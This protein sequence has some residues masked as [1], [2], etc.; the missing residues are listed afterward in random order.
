MNHLIKSVLCAATLATMNLAGAADLTINIDDVKSEAGSI[1]VA[2][3]NTSD[4]FLKTPVKQG[5]A[6]A[7]LAG[8]KI[9]ITDLPPGDY[10]FSLYQDLNDNGKIDTNLMG[11]P[12]EPYAFSNNAMGSMGPPSFDN[13]KF[14]V[15]S[16]AVAATVTL[17]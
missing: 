5:A 1:L 6:K 8:T 9:V 10:A 7:K 12:N 11:I 13:A 4:A 17:R 16:A 3:Y 15:K 14:A 2:V